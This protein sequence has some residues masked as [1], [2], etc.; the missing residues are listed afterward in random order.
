MDLVT[1]PTTK[2]DWEKLERKV[3]NTTH[4][5]LLDSIFVNV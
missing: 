2:E 3:R 5:Y 1:K 4:L